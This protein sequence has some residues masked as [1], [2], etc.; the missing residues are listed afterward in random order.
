MYYGYVKQIV[1]YYSDPEKTVKSHASLIS[2]HVKADPRFF[3]TYD[4]YEKNIAKSANG[5]QSGNGRGN[6]MGMWGGGGFGFNFGMNGGLFSYGGDSVSIVDF[7][8]KRNEYIHSK[9]GF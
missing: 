8:I 2:D 4:Q 3:F 9:L 7:M 6:G 1:N 5:L